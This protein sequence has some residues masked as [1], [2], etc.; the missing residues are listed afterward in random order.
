[1]FSQVPLLLA[2]AAD[3]DA[4]VRKV[5][6]LSARLAYALMCATLCWGVLIATGWA[7]RL[8]GR[9]GLRNGH[10]VLASVAIAFGSL[11]AIAF[12]LLQVGTL[13]LPAP[14]LPVR[15]RRPV[16][17]RARHRRTRADDRR[18]P[19]PRGLRHKSLYR[20]VA[21]AA[22][23][24]LRRRRRDRRTLL[25]RRGRQRQ[26]RTAVARPVSR[27]S[28]R[29]STLAVARFLPPEVLARIGMLETE[30]RAGDGEGDAM[31][32]SVNNERCHRYG[33]CQAEAPQLFQLIEDN[34]LQLHPRPRPEDSSRRRAPRHASCPMRAIEL[35]GACAG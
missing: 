1:M 35:Q 28:C 9:Q 24:R 26:P 17:A 34:R 10:M 29:P 23:A 32:I 19:S 15:R 16:P 27:S 18:S 30:V 22:P 20:Q 25:A 21:A 7:E 14:G 5:A 4:G 12:T 31:D 8:T 2:D 6:Q 13:R 11:H 3:H 33:I